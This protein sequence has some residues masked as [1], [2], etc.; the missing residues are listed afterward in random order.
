VTLLEDGTAV[1]SGSGTMI[2]KEGC[3]IGGSNHL[4]I[5]KKVLWELECEQTGRGS[6]VGLVQLPKSAKPEETPD[7]NLSLSAVGWGIWGGTTGNF[8]PSYIKGSVSDQ[9]P[10]FTAGQRIGL[11]CD[12]V[13]ASL[14][15]LLDGQEI[16]VAFEDLPV[17]DS[18]FHLAVSNGWAGCTRLRLTGMQVLDGPMSS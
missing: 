2:S 3:G 11:L 15:Y 7:L 14:T 8:H 17:E 1:I 10:A 5:G 18:A 13:K 16:C 6:W 4:C 9:L 12:S